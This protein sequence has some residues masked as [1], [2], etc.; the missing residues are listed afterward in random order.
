MAT[1]ETGLF[2]PCQIRAIRGM[3][4][5]LYLCTLILLIRNISLRE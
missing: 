1:D 3:E 4:D 2:K 5:I